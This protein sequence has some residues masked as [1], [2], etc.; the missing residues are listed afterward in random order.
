MVLSETQPP[1]TGLT[2]IRVLREG[3]RL[4]KC[5]GVTEAGLMT[6]DETC[7]RTLSRIAESVGEGNAPTAR[8][9]IRALARLHRQL[10][11]IVAL[12]CLPE[13]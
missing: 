5:L 10:R 1:W 12:S 11:W 4:D 7:S 13:T 6:W 3:L 9:W 2:L 8:S